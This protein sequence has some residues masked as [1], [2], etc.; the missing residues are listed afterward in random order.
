VT[1]AVAAGVPPAVE[2]WRPARR[3]ESHTSPSRWNMGA[4][5]RAAGCQP[6]QAGATPAATAVVQFAALYAISRHP[7]SRVKTKKSVNSED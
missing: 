7:P 4:L 6:T 3:K 2:P 1:T 5:I